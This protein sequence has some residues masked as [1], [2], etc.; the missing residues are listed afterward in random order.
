MPD[1]VRQC[2]T[3]GT[4]FCLFALTVTGCGVLPSDVKVRGD[5]VFTVT[6]SAMPGR[7]GLPGARR[8]AFEQADAHC[9]RRPEMQVLVLAERELAPSA[10]EPAAFATLD[11]KC[12]TAVQ[13]QAERARLH[14]SAFPV[15]E[16]VR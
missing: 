8:A 12:L 10:T 9:A 2:L 13:A 7:G 14:L 6:G 16:V 4:S 11:F 3:A 1:S 15:T 5:Q